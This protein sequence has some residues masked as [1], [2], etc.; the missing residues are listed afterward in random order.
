M[1]TRCPECETD[2]RLDVNHLRIGYGKVK[3]GR[4]GSVFDALRTLA[5]NQRDIGR[6][7]SHAVPELDN[8]NV[9][10]GYAMSDDLSTAESVLYYDDENAPA[11]K[12]LPLLWLISIFI[13]AALLCI[14]IILTNVDRLA[15]HDTAR[16]W[17]TKICIFLNCQVPTYRNIKQVDMLGHTLSKHPDRVLEF[18]LLLANRAPFPQSFPPVRLT[19]LELNGEAMASR[20][21]FP[22]E[23]LSEQLLGSLMPVKKPQDI[24]IRIVHPGND[25]GGYTFKLL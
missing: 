23:Y 19:L 2:Y 7:T 8:E 18:K 3:C 20:V 21:I 13:L 22:E 24:N 16:P 4:C 9:V 5:E 10:Q 17:L 11:S 25:V 6:D 12:Q 1:F 15:H 14:Q